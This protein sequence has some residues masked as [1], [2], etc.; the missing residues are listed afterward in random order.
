MTYGISRSSQHVYDCDRIF[1][2]FAGQYITEKNVPHTTHKDEW[3]WHTE[4]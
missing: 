3:I 4:A 1:E 2:G